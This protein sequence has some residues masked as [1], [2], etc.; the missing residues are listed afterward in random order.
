M[1]KIII[2][3]RCVRS[4]RD[5]LDEARSWGSFSFSGFYVGE[6]IKELLLLAPRGTQWQSEDYLMYVVVRSCRQG[7]LTG[8]VLKAKR[9]EE[10]TCRD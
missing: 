8:E 2:V 4:W 9:L 10:L 3:S 7:I 1:K 5:E 6:E